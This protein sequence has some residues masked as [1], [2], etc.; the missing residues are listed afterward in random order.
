[1]KIKITN[2]LKKILVLF[3]LLI[4]NSLNA[5]FFEDIT[6]Q[7]ADNPKRLSYGVSVTDVNQD[8]NFDFIVTGFG[9]LNLALSF[10]N[11]KLINI[12][13]QKKF[14]DKLRRTIGVA[15]CDV[16]KDGYEEIYFLN[17]DTYSG[18][19]KYSDR[20]LDLEQDKYI[21]LFE[22]E[23]NQNDLNLTAGRSVVC[24][25]RNGDGNYGV[26][27]AN[28][29][30]PTRFYEIESGEIKDKAVNLNL[31]KVTGG[32]AVVSGHILTDRSDIF[33]ANERGANYLFKNKNG[34]FEDVAFEYRVD[35]AIQNGRGTALSDIY[36]R[37]RLDILSGNWIGY[38]RAYVLKNNE[39]KDIGNKNF[40]KPSRIRTIISAD[41][42]N[43]GFDEVFMNNIAEPNKL[44]KIKE[45][46]KFEEIK[47][48]VGLEADGYGTGAA[49]ADI[50]NDGV[51][52]LLV[53]RGESKEQSLTLYKAK[54]NKHSRY[55]RIKP[56]NKFGAP[57]RGATVTLLTNQRKHSKTIDA[58]SGYLCQMEPVAH[59]GIRKNEKD[60]RVEIRWTNGTKDLI[61]IN[62]LNQTVTVK[63][64]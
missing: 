27:V 31:D 15:A 9:Y 37:G 49:V 2:H 53:A 58:G 33:A 43:D 35:D 61:E 62:S 54:V 5:D 24:V 21:D 13:N 1:M 32:R 12:I 26:Y 20:L 52:E 44:F 14:S 28:Y 4:P 40:D 59:Y 23:K 29:G 42:D 50:D 7:I 46:G 51:L 60:F 8:G 19:K 36:Y 3:F 48:K 45:N 56:I 16:D 38:H 6:S 25:D 63:Q 30:G 39:F 10:E 41:F 11:G 17:T 57:A 18:T 55:L 22:I 64:R 47:L 34:K